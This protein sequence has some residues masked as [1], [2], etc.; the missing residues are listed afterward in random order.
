MAW[1]TYFHKQVNLQEVA[2]Y[3][4]F[5]FKQKKTIPFNYPEIV[6]LLNTAEFHNWAVSNIYKPEVISK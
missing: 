5:I 2:I 3:F 6:F 1:Q 4:N